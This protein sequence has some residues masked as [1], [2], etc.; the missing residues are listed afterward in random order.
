M[1]IL[2]RILQAACHFFRVLADFLKAAA[3]GAPLAPGLRIFSPDPAAMR[4]RLAW[5]AAYR[6]GFEAI[7]LNPHKLA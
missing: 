6:P 1:R 4:A 7:L 5:I 2:T 3:V